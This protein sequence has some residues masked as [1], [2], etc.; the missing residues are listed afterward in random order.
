MLCETGRLRDGQEYPSTVRKVCKLLGWELTA[1]ASAGE[2]PSKYLGH[3]LGDP[4]EIREKL[5]P[6]LSRKENRDLPMLYR[7]FRGK[8]ETQ[9]NFGSLSKTPEGMA[10]PTA[11]ISTMSFTGKSR[12]NEIPF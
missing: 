10:T 1:E 8:Y 12:R 11:T 4:E 5:A 6:F 9:R 3:D 7:R 2:F